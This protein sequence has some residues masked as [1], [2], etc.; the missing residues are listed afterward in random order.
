MM[1]TTKFV[2]QFLELK[3]V[4]NIF[5]K[6][7]SFQIIIEKLNSFLFLTNGPAQRKHQPTANF[8]LSNQR[9]EGEPARLGPS[10]H[11]CRPREAEGEGGTAT[12][13]RRPRRH[14][15][16]A[17]DD[18]QR[19]SRP[20]AGEKKHARS[21]RRDGEHRAATQGERGCR[22]WS[23]SSVARPR[24]RVREKARLSHTVG[25]QG[26]PWPVRRRG[27]CGGAW[28]ARNRA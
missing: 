6:Y 24:W 14:G 28:R 18:G 25:E 11:G 8:G 5:S 22:C 13:C 16:A 12:T 3:W 19:P 2:S 20:W 4:H 7:F 21:P 26:T 23:T 10:A 17:V 27:G 9:G 1:I 15:S